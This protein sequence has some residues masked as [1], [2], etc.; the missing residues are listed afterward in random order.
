M[1]V[2][3]RPDNDGFMTLDGGS[4]GTGIDEKRI[5]V[6][7]TMRTAELMVHRYIE[8]K[9]RPCFTA[10]ATSALG[11]VGILESSIL[12]AGRVSKRRRSERDTRA[13]A[14]TNVG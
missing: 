11:S 3:N 2:V 8:R 5:K 9:W 12:V 10:R 13:R 6:R 1:V 14:R 4:L 7:E